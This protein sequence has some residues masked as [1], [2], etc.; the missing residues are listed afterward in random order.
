M[1]TFRDKYR[2]NVYSQNGEDGIIEEICKRI[3]LTEGISIEI[4]APDTT[5]CSNTANLKGFKK[6][7]YDIDPRGEGVIKKEITPANV[8][9]VG[10]CDILSI[11][12]DGNDHDV[13]MAYKFQPK[14]VIIEINSSLDPEEEF[15][16]SDKGA[17]YITMILA[18][19]KKGY[20][21]ICHTGNIIFVDSKYIHLFPELKEDS[22]LN[23]F[24][25]SWL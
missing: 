23:Y 7:F 5:Y 17:S 2:Y 8:N 12:I 10:D 25:K 16:S 4:G 13:W 3:N 18:G 14:I 22:V 11:D 21:P 6:S 15:F 20:T 19:L 1:L 9:E 24:D